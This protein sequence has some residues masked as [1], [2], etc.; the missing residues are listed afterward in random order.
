MVICYFESGNRCLAP[1]LSL[2][3]LILLN[4]S[5]DNLYEVGREVGELAGSIKKKDNNTCV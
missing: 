2:G 1:N 3:K 5:I 4:Q